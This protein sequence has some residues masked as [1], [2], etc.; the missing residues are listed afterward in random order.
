META[1]IN[2]CK[3]PAYFASKGTLENILEAFYKGKTYNE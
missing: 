2:M 1:H 3:I